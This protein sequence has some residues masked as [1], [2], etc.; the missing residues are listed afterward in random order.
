VAGRRI[1]VIVWSESTE[2]KTVY[3]KGIHGELAN[4]LNTVPG[5][6]AKT[7]QL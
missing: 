6:N 4:Y 3:P 7:A 2:P 1:R 5:V